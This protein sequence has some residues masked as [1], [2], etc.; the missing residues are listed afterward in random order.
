M[1][2]VLVNHRTP[3]GGS[4]CACCHTELDIGYIR[5]MSSLRV[6]CGTKCYERFRKAFPHSKSAAAATLSPMD[7]SGP[8]VDWVTPTEAH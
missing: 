5:E 2:F 4:A 1:Q 7:L 3:R 8:Y 6:F